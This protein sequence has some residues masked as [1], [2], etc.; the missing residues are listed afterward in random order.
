MSE[1]RYDRNH[2]VIRNYEQMVNISHE[3]TLCLCDFV[4]YCIATGG[5]SCRECPIGKEKK[6]Y[7]KL[8]NK[9][10]DRKEILF[11][12]ETAFLLG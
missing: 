11:H 3:K 4:K 6:K 5:T 1:S 7:R 9:P 2:L 10:I 12:I 8:V